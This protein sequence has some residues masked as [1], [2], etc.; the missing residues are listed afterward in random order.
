MLDRLHGAIRG[1][2]EITDPGR[3]AEPEWPGEG[4]PTLT[5]RDGRQPWWDPGADRSVDP[6]TDHVLVDGRAVA[7]GSRI[8]LRPGRRRT[9][10][11]DIFV[12]GRTASVEAVLHDVDGLVHIA[13][14]LED[15]PG[16]DIQRAQGR[17]LYFQ[18]D[19]VEVV[20][21]A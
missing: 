14:T 13:V 11:Q 10:A 21:P 20:E 3:D 12:E 7:R 8:R 19:E 6:T 17:F 18:P 5:D 9:D 2:R 1:L 15:D 16:A 4:F